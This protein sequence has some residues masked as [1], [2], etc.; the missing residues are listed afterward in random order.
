MQSA[1]LKTRA[2]MCKRCVHTKTMHMLPP[3]THTNCHLE[4]C[5]VRSVCIMHRLNLFSGGHYIVPNK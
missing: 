3:H 1:L 5:E 4:E 2:W